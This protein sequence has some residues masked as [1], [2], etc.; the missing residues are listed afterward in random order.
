MTT[1]SEWL[2]IGHLTS[3]AVTNLVG[4]VVSDWS[5]AWFS[6][7][8]IKLSLLRPADGQASR[9][10]WSPCGPCRLGVTRSGRLKLALL[11]LDASSEPQPMTDADL[12]IIEG[13]QAALVKD[14]GDRLARLLEVKSSAENEGQPGSD[15]LIA[16]LWAENIEICQLSFCRN[17]I[18]ALARRQAPP[19]RIHDEAPVSRIEALGPNRVALEA[20]FGSVELSLAEIRN[21]AVGDVLVLD[22]ALNDPIALL[23]KPQGTAIVAGRLTQLDDHLALA[24]E[25]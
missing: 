5:E 13:V 10:D 22:T 21:L 7:S 9:K 3:T 8:Q 14:L 2:P 1:V 24:L 23:L 15:D 19:R 20:H 25:S 12:Q 18:A 17:L 4:R 6:E 11:A 16:T